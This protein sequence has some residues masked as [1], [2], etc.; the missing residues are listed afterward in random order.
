MP[1]IDDAFALLAAALDSEYIGEPISQLAHA[2]HAAQL[3]VRAGADDDLVLA[4]LFHDVG[5]L[6]IESA[7][8][9]G[10]V[11]VRHHERLGADY[12]RSAGFSARTASLVAMHVDAK[13]YLV[14]TRPH[15]ARALSPASAETLQHQGGA[16]N[17]SE[18]LA[19][20]AHPLSSDALR[21]R[22]WDE[23]A[24][25]ADLVVPDLACHRARLPRA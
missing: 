2:L 11:G 12:L 20:E 21:L 4:A 16:M 18:C 3:A 22:A 24:K 13:R 23:A 14:A 19:F 9:M 1:S 8:R 5:H 15:Y 10:S 6:C 7:P 17:P 25:L